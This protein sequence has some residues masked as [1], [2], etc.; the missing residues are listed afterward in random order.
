MIVKNRLLNYKDTIIYQDDNCFEFSIDSVLLANFVTIK[1][2]T[3]KIIDLCC[4]NAPIPMLLSFRTNSKIFGVEIQQDIYNMGIASIKDNKMDKQ[5]NLL[6][7]DVKNVKE[8]LNSEEFDLVTCNPP[9]FKYITSSLVNDCDKKT[10]ARH[11]V[12]LTLED[13]VKSSKYLLKNGGTFAMVHR[14]S[15]LL[16]IIDVM[17][18]YKI[19]PKRLR[20]VYSKKNKE[21]NMILIEGIKNGKADLKILPPLF[22]YDEAG[23]YTEEV[24][25]MFGGVNDVAK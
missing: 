18:K 11:E 2:T 7:G 24:K 15:R 19:E 17:R 6:C 22:I 20:M 25:R 4:G 8:Y 1:L 21:C 5:I 13:V 14:P 10:I 16:E 12:L 23:N 3:K 9:Y